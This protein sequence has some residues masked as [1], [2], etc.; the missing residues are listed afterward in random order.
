MDWKG[1]KVGNYVTRKAMYLHSTSQMQQR[2]GVPILQ[3]PYHMLQN[4]PN[5]NPKDL[6]GKLPFLDSL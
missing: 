3:Q 5:Y 6:L 2:A 1:E 4:S